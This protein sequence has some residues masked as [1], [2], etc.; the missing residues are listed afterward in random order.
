MALSL[1]LVILL[2]LAADW[3]FRKFRIPGLVGMLLVGVL[4]GPFVL[5][6]LDERLLAVGADLRLIA[7]VVILLRAGLELSKKT[8]HKVGRVVLLLSFV[9]ALCEGVAI[10][11][12][13]PHLLGLSR[14]ASAVLGS[15]LAAVSPAVV[16]HLMVRFIDRGKGVEKGIPTLV[17]AASALDDVIV[18]VIYS[19]L[20]GFYTGRRVNVAWKLAGI[21]L[22]I[23]LG[24]LVGAGVGA[25][26]YR[27]FER[28]QP[29]ATKQ[30]LIVLAVCVLLVH[31]E[32]VGKGLVPFAA[33]VAVMSIGFIFLERR[34]HM[35]HKLS[36][37]LGKIWVPAEI[38][39]FVMVGAQV[40]IGAAWR[41]GLAG[42]LLICLG[43]MARSLGTY[44]CLLGSRLNL[45]ERLFVV[46]S[47]LPKATVQ[48]AI[49]AAP[50]A[51]M[52][53]AGMDNAP[54]E[55][56]LTVAVLSILLTAPLGAWA[57]AATGERVLTCSPALENEARRAALESEAGTEE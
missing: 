45:K 30:V 10:T 53:L 5:G 3:S 55:I 7:L 50:L 49:G 19:V 35:A 40:D 51:A 23:L 57:I 18:I 12:L 44:L 42:T 2:S 4:T 14:M 33:L 47:Y 16:V 17:L 36:A 56:I 29:R 41:S 26:L 52:K 32:R 9:P 46:V 31:L 24:I 15:V 25:L 8:L 20:I 34:E 27:L 38:I 37:K 54:G 28:F 43:L 21:P 39:L 1:A 6:W 22:S 11:A 13:G 48:A